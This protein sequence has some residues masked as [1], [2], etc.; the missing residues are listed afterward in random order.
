MFDVSTTVAEA[1]GVTTRNL[2]HWLVKEKGFPWRDDCTW[3]DLRR[4]LTFLELPGTAAEASFAPDY[5]NWRDRA[6]QVLG[7]EG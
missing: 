5:P 6:R 1:A 3:D 4:M 2:A 7:D